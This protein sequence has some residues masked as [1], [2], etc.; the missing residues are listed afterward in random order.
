LK[1]LTQNGELP[2]P[3]ILPQE[4]MGKLEAA[5]AKL[6]GILKELGEEVSV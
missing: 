3:A 6:R 4:A 2:K 1:T 5:I